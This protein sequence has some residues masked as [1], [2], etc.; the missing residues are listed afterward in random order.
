[1]RPGG[2]RDVAYVLQHGSVVCRRHLTL[3]LHPALGSW[4]VRS[5][6]HE[7]TAAVRD[8]LIQEGR[9]AS[10]GTLHI[11]VATPGA[12]IVTTPKPVCG[13]LEAVAF[14]AE[15]LSAAGFGD[16]PAGTAAAG[17]AAV[18]GASLTVPM[19]DGELALDVE[20]ELVLCAGPQVQ[21]SGTVEV[22]LTMQ[23]P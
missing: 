1:M 15:R 9:R 3:E 21:G 8:S 14:A 23:A 10:H 11:Y 20:Q 6:K 22:V 5:C 13:P 16:L 17:S 2:R 12:A 7:M 18:L 19:R 4:L